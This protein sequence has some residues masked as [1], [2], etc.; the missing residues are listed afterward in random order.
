[1]DPLLHTRSLTPTSAPQAS[2]EAAPD[3]AG[4]L[5]LASPESRWQVQLEFDSDSPRGS[6]TPLLSVPGAAPSQPSAERPS[7][8]PIVGKFP[9]D[10]CMNGY[11][12]PLDQTDPVLGEAPRAVYER[13]RARWE[14]RSIPAFWGPAA[15]SA[16]ASLVPTEVIITAGT[17][18]VACEVGGGTVEV[19]APLHVASADGRV[20]VEAA[21]Q[22]ALSR[23]ENH[24]GIFYVNASAQTAWSA[25]A[26]FAQSTGLRDVDLRGAEYGSLAISHGDDPSD[27]ELRG[28]LQV[29]QWQGFLPGP[30]QYPVLRW[31]AG[32]SCELRRC[33]WTT[34]FPD[35]D[36]AAL[37]RP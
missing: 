6:F 36:C 1:L 31:C 23:A 4:T 24:A 5:E 11:S 14:G 18:A 12:L 34:D 19:H 2:P 22:I 7:W 27:D 37:D 15:S 3:F 8:S 32:P 10:G 21:A 33:V 9:D 16:G 35:R 28:E 29:S 26:E 17:A 13:A 25:A 30:A 20:S